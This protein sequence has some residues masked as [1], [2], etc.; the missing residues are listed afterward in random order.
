MEE[1]SFVAKKDFIFEVPGFEVLS[2]VPV[3]LSSGWNLVGIHGYSETYT[4]SSL[5]DSISSVEGLGA[6]NV[7][8][9]PTNKG[10]YEG[11]QKSEGTEYGFDFPIRE[12]LGYFVRINKFEPK[13]TST[14]SI[15]WNPGT[16]LNGQPGSN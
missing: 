16:D 1:V 10:R 13:A 8:Y 14:K 2:G 5:I 9:W 11:L 7:T 15:I 3:A 6:D 12:D 4:A